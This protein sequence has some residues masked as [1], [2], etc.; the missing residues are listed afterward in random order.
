MSPSAFLLVCQKR[1][2]LELVVFSGPECER[3]Q[4]NANEMEVIPRNQTAA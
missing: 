3:R 4:M 1:L 2:V